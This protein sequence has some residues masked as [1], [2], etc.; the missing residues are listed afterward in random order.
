MES[1][2]YMLKV[3]LVAATVFMDDTSDYFEP[4]KKHGIVNDEGVFRPR[5]DWVSTA[6]ELAEL[7]GRLCYKSWSRPNPASASN[8]AYLANIISQGHFSVLEHASATF[9]IQG[10]SRSLTHELVRHRHLSFSQVSQRYV[11]EGTPELSLD[12]MVY[13]PDGVGDIFYEGAVQQATRDAR[14]TYNTLVSHL[15]SLG[16]DRKTARGIARG[17][18]PNA[19]ETELVVTGNHRTWREVLGK[20]LSPTADG[21]IR[22]LAQVLLVELHDLAPN[23][24]QDLWEEFS[25][26]IPE[27][28]SVP[29]SQTT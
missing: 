14:Q 27:A 13:H 21:E 26:D 28:L 6:D 2:S 3:K 23:T 4:Y 18:L 29:Y 10:V 17:L 11:D 20:R 19:V 7:A 1:E 25:D 9:W 8:P 12:G 16:N 15:V 22:Q 5:E 24:Y